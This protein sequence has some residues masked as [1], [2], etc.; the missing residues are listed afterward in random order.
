MVFTKEQLELG[1]LGFGFDANNSR[2]CALH[3]CATYIYIYIYDQ[4]L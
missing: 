1:V 3:T 4:K 2:I